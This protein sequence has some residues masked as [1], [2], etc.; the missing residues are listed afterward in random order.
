MSMIKRL[1]S[2]EKAYITEGADSGEEARRAELQSYATVKF[3]EVFIDSQLRHL[4]PICHKLQK[5]AN[6]NWAER[7]ARSA[8]D[9]AQLSSYVEDIRIAL[10]DY[11]VRSTILNAFVL[12]PAR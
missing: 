10:V 11:Q 4:L 1:E 7:L 2:F 12:T 8:H 6:Q 9:E 5:M 3:S